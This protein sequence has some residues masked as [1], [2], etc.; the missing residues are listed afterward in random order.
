MS[1]RPSFH[2]PLSA[3]GPDGAAVAGDVAAG[4]GLPPGAALLSPG[5]AIVAAAGRW[6]PGDVY[7]VAAG[8]WVA[9]CGS[10]IYRVIPGPGCWWYAGRWEGCR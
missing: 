6:W 3:I 4:A 9:V 5:A 10:G 2:A 7:R 8:A 1:L